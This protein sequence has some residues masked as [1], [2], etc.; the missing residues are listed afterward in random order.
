MIRRSGTL[1][2]LLLTL[3]SA[4]GL[5]QTEP[6]EETS[7]YA[8]L[9]NGSKIGHNVDTRHVDGDTVTN[10]SEMRMTLGRGEHQITVHTRSESVETIDGTPLSFR[11]DTGTGDAFIRTVE[12]VVTDGQIHATVHGP[13][14]D[15]EITMPWPEGAVMDEGESRITER[16]GLEERTTYTVDLFDEESLSVMSI[17]TTI[18][19][20]EEI[21]LFG[22]VVSLV[23]AE[24]RVTV[25]EG[26]ITAIA[27][28]NDDYELLKA[29]I[30]LAGMEMEIIACDQAFA[31]SPDQ[32]TDFVVNCQTPSP[33]AIPEDRRDA[34]TFVLEPQPDWNFEL[35]GDATQRVEVLDDGRV[36]VTV[37]PVTPPADAPLPY[38]G[39]DEDVLAALEP[40]RY[41]ESDN[42]A[43]IAAAREA[44]GDADNAAE[45][46]QRLQQ[47]VYD[48]VTT[49]DLSVG[50]ASA[51]EVLAS[52]QGDCTE[53]AVLLAAMCRA[54]GIPTELVDGLVYVDE[55]HGAQNVL[56][57]HAWVRC[58]IGDTWVH[59]DAAWLGT[60]AARIMLS[61]GD[62]FESLFSLVGS[63]GQFDIVEI[64]DADGQPLPARDD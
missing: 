62:G 55:A 42:E 35:P 25:G 50:Y 31:E 44:I 28:V 23:R 63:L 59:A 12:G 64:R 34:L 29:V 3:T 2:F 32:I 16:M 19:P 14:G 26:S 36:E 1:A 37:T 41:V 11:H 13:A 52:R 10:I 30:P 17:Q 51:A 61:R 60:D 48:Y 53:H 40:S 43:I 20:R 8:V 47:F 58:Y 6:A 9:F 18:G 27:Y 49:K 46:L 33:A 54:V 4:S 38:G 7:Y 39:D 57:P 21:D 45:A 24:G 5:A 22:R 56:S 15:E